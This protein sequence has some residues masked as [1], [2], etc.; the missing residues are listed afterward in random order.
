MNWEKGVAIVAAGVTWYLNPTVGWRWCQQRRTGLSARSVIGPKRACGGALVPIAPPL[1]CNPHPH[2]H[3]PLTSHL[4]PL[5]LTPIQARRRRPP[6]RLC[7]LVQGQDCHGGGRLEGGLVQG[8][9]GGR[10]RRRAGVVFRLRRRKP[11]VW[12]SCEF[13]PGWPLCTLVRCRGP[14]WG[15]RSIYSFFE[16]MSAA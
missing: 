10:Q 15:L 11:Q 8:G 7:H 6:R 5:T 9:G 3:P 13:G 2:P 16:V 1:A 4:S 12:N 14:R